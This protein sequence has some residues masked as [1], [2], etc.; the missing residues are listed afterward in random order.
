MKYA[1]KWVPLLFLAVL[2]IWY[3][4]G[5]L[6][7]IGNIYFLCSGH[8]GIVALVILD[9]LVYFHLFDADDGVAWV[10]VGCLIS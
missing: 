2:E 7:V 10:G 6:L 5:V 8:V 3:C 9:F 4:T 1:V